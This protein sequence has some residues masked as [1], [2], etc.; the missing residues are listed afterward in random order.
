LGQDAAIAGDYKD[1]K[2]ENSTDYPVYIEA[3]IDDNMLVPVIKHIYKFLSF[4]LP[5]FSIK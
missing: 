5:P 2:F 4:H 1:L 3:Y